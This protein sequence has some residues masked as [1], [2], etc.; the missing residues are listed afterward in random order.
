MPDEDEP[1]IEDAPATWENVVEGE[2]EKLVGEVIRDKHLV[3]EGED[4]IETA[5]EVREEY[6]EQHEEPKHPHDS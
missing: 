2:V 6:R 5:H 1:E 3:E 4:R